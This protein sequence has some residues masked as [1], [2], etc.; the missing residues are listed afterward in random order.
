MIVIP[1]NLQNRVH[2]LDAFVQHSTEEEMRTIVE[3]GIIVDKLKCEQPDSFSIIKT[4]INENNRLEME[5]VNMTSRM[6][7]METD[8]RDLLKVLDR[9]IYNQINGDFYNL[10]SRNYIY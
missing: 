7:K 1:A 9:T 5:L 3:K 6:I 8:F 4:L 2:L 10:K